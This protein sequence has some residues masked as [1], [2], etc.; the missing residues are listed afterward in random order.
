MEKEPESGEGDK[1]RLFE[2][3]LWGDILMF[4]NKLDTLLSST[5]ELDADA[6]S[7]SFIVCN[8]FLH[9]SALLVIL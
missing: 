9:S 6:T 3:F 1:R 4:P 2:A 7:S 8:L 5:L